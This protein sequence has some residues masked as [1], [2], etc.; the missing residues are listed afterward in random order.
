VPVSR[1]S[2]FQKRT[3]YWRD[4]HSTL[5]LQGPVK[6]ELLSTF[7]LDANAVLRSGAPF[8]ADLHHVPTI[9]ARHSA[10]TPPPS[11]PPPAGIFATWLP[12]CAVREFPSSNVRDVIAPL[13]CLLYA[14]WIR[15]NTQRSQSRYAP[16]H[17]ILGQV[18]QPLT[19][20]Y[21][22]DAYH[23]GS[24]RQHRVQDWS[25]NRLWLAAA[26]LLSASFR[27]TELPT[28]NA[29]RLVLVP[30]SKYSSFGA[31]SHAVKGRAFLQIWGCAPLVS[32]MSKRA[33]SSQ[34]C[35]FWRASTD[36]PL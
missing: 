7:C 11:S 19:P 26:E 32:R 21:L 17:P 27:P 10:T 36:K 31:I 25:V 3:P 12:R 28:P 6:S 15:D 9:T 34:D 33:V 13:S 2:A 1:H 20:V 35:R 14:G 24:L 30:L 23:A 18:Y 8:L 5:R 29:C 16:H 4:R 22:N